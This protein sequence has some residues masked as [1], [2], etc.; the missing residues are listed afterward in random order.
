MTGFDTFVVVDWSARSQPSPATPTADS[1]W[2]AV[3]R[4]G[5]A[6]TEYLRTR[7]AAT[8]RLVRIFEDEL[9]LGRRVLAG[10][11]FPFG[12]PAG[13][14][15]AVAG[16]PD[17]LALWAALAERV[18]DGE[19]NGND[20]FTAAA[21]LNAVFPGTGPFWGRP[22]GL[23]LPGLPERGSERDGH[24]LP[25]R[26]AVEA[27]VPRAQP[28]WK[29]FTTG[30][31]GS[32]ALLGLPR[33]HALRN[34]F[35]D[36]LSVWPFESPDAPIVLAEVYPSLVDA[37]VQEAI[38]PEDIK[39]EVQVRVLARA[40][41][42]MQAQ[43]TLGHALT[44]P[45]APALAEEGWI[46]GVGAE[47]AL[48][49]AARAALAPPKLGNDCFALPPGVH[50]T[51]VDEALTLLRDR[52]A[53]VTATETVPVAGAE[54]RILAAD[55]LARR[56][57]PPA[58]NSAVDGYGF[59]GQAVGEGAQRLPLL[60]GRAAAGAPYVGAVPQGAAIR[61]LTGAT[62]PE[63]VDTV[64]LEEDTTR[65]GGHVAFNGPVRPGANTRRAGED[66]EAG[67]VA[68]EAG[69][70]LRAPDLA[71]LS[72]LGLAEA[73]VHRR[74]RVAV[75]STGDELAAPGATADPARTFDANRPMLLSLA[76]RWGYA[77]VD[78]GHVPDD[79]E[80]LAARLDEARKTADVL[81]TSGGASAGDEDHVSALLRE[82]GALQAWRIALKPG[83]PLALGMWDG[84]PI[85]G[86]PGNP[87][88]AFVCTLI[89]ARPAL[90][91]L[92]GGRWLAPRGFDVPAAFEKRKKPGRR[93]YLRARLTPEG[94]AEVFRS[95]GSGRI[96]GLSWAEGLVELGDEGRHV[97]RG[98]PVRFL[99]Y[100]SFGI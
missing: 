25:E 43:G 53:P 54:G 4:D 24:G 48:R 52:L 39:D 32:Q 23:D 34:R 8:E 76:S 2:I 47:D 49:T 1:I 70:L 55:H 71:L 9:A 12:Y 27:L 59:A 14:A 13:F 60:E 93:E 87:V 77:P 69:H 90:S 45:D 100:G 50:W 20:R 89:F 16:R 66:V 72:A 61:I 22:A 28:C 80:T 38:G 85:F 36:R 74:L 5:R 67:A 6:T 46:L 84:M 56:S 82:R 26:R 31:V 78:L 51:P 44:A 64:V 18:E 41:E 19:D 11:D 29:L 92:A 62:L 15:E 17:A 33:L 99:P 40:L 30:S 65:A 73:H 7:A 96:S 95:E 21:A 98:D 83:R 10:F 94:H 3:A 42:E 63:G 81:L 68:L 86:L 97:H 57:N 58:P 75:V 79:R 35:G 37:V 88:A 91:R